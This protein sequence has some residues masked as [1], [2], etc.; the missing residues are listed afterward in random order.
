MSWWSYQSAADRAKKKKRAVERVT[1][2]GREMTPVL[3]GHRTKLSTTFWGQAWNRNLESYMDYESRLPRGRTYLRAGN[4]YNL[5]IGPGVITS[6]VMG[7]R[8]YS[9]KVQIVPFPSHRWLKLKE[10]C[11]GQVGSLIDLLAGRLG[12]G[13]MA[14]ITDKT[15]GLFPAPKEIRFDCSCPDWADMCK[16]VAATLYAVGC[17][18]DSQPELFFQLR[19]LDH[20]EL[21]AQAG[22]SL[23]DPAGTSANELE[24]N[25]LSALFGIDLGSDAEEAL[26]AVDVSLSAPPP[27]PKPSASRKTAARATKKSAAPAARKKAA[28]ATK[29]MAARKKPSKS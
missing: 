15:G 26:K 11:A 19:G 4:V 22:A 8:L 28:S 7:Q 6:N 14:L 17:Q 23:T 21:A 13:V 12:D 24:G 2:G 20:T 29:K 3:P 25:D 10:Q 16:H 9:V 1:R 18:L 5:G 27:A